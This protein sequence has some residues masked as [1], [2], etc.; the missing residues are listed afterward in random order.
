MHGGQGPTFKSGGVTNEFYC[1][2]SRLD[3]PEPYILFRH[4]IRFSD[5]RY[6]AHSEIDGEP[7][8]DPYYEG[9]AADGAALSDACMAQARTLAG[10]AI[11]AF[12]AKLAG[13]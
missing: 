10:I 13:S 9:P 2:V 11:S 8:G 7:P 5:G 6:S 3:L 12:N 1:V 4:I